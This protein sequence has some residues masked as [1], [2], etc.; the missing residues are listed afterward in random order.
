MYRGSFH[1]LARQAADALVRRDG[2]SVMIMSAKHGLLDLDQVIEPYDITIKQ[3]SHGR[4]APGERQ[5]ITRMVQ[6]LDRAE[7]RHVTMLLPYDYRRVLGGAILS[8]GLARG[9]LAWISKS[10]PLDGCCGIGDQRHVLTE[11][12]D[13][14]RAAV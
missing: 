5:L 7:V 14:S 2:G 1:R 10:W 8:L 3:L 11:L 13:G 9:D 12:R 6:Q 4:N